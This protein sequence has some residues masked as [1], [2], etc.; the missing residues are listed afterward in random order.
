MS[1]RRHCWSPPR[2]AITLA[3]AF[4]TAC[5]HASMMCPSARTECPDGSLAH[6]GYCLSA[7]GARNGPF[8]QDSDLGTVAHGSY[9][10]DRLEG[11]FATCEGDAI[12]ALSSYRNGLLDGVSAAFSKEGRLAMESTYAAGKLNGSYRTWWPNGEL[13]IEGTYKADAVDGTWKGWHANGKQRFV[14]KHDAVACA[15]LPSSNDSTTMNFGS[16]RV[17]VWRWWRTDGTLMREVDYG[18]GTQSPHPEESVDNPY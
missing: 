7:D 12:V 15:Q 2:R 9:L 6:G 14:G 17:G 8:Q 10:N 18:L 5:A 13:A 3:L 16:C 1:R 11:Q 4:Q